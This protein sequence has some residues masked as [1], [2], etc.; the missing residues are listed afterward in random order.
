M[1]EEE[2]PP[3]RPNGGLLLEAADE[4]SM[5]ELLADGEPERGWL[6]VCA[7]YPSGKSPGR[8]VDIINYQ[9]DPM[10]SQGR[11]RS[12]SVLINRKRTDD[13][14]VSSRTVL[15][16]VVEAGRTAKL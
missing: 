16:P 11:L 7:E 14:I 4:G 12:R 13:L 6:G 2:S 9:V 10:R 1:L 3:T 15:G 8:E 5:G